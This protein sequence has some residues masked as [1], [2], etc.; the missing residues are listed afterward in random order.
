MSRILSP[1]E[2]DELASQKVLADSFGDSASSG[3][4]ERGSEAT[5][6]RSGVPGV[7]VLPVLQSEYM[8]RDSAT[9]GL[10]LLRST[11]PPCH[12]LLVPESSLF[13]D[14]NPSV[15]RLLKSRESFFLGL[16]LL[17]S[18][19]LAA[20]PDLRKDLSVIV[21][22]SLA[23]SFLSFS[24]RGPKKTCS[25]DEQDEVDAASDT[26]E[27]A[28]AVEHCEFI[29]EAEELLLSC[30]ELLS[31]GMLSNWLRLGDWAANNASLPG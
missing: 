19:R 16:R 31:L 15:F 23:T 27:A 2:S 3:L 11:S 30:L 4:S 14:E 22:P 6:A 26:V 7:S 10:F 8:W 18:P 1:C 28:D 13:L 25:T 5:T 20:S 21:L 12:L 24:D 9:I 29:D 17:G